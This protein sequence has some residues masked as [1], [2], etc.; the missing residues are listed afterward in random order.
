MFLKAKQYDQ[1]GTVDHEYDDEETCECGQNHNHHN[2][3]EFVA[4]RVKIE[5]CH[6]AD[7]IS[8]FSRKCST[9]TTKLTALM[10]S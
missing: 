10:A 6:C 9:D 4:F 5:L 1:F 2:F 8:H 7:P 3:E